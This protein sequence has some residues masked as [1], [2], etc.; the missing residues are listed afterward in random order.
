MSQAVLVVVAAVGGTPLPPYIGIEIWALLTRRVYTN[1][2]DEQ[3]SHSPA[4]PV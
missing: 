2:K 3:A 4:N 1:E